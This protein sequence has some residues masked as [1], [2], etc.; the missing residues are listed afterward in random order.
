[1]LAFAACQTPNNTTWNTHDTLPMGTRKETTNERDSGDTTTSGVKCKVPVHAIMQTHLH[2]TPTAQQLVPMGPRG[3]TCELRAN[4]AKVSAP[5]G[6]VSNSFWSA[7]MF[8]GCHTLPHHTLATRIADVDN[9]VLCTLKSNERHLQ[10][11][12][13]RCL[14]PWGPRGNR[15]QV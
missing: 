13:P 7:V 11:K 14:A 3:A 1:M 9:W 15:K 8:V 2:T 4:R 12:K 5:F 6:Q 10:E